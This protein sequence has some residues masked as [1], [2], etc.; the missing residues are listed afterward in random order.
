MASSEHPQTP[1]VGIQTSPDSAVSAEA[2][3]IPLSPL[4]RPPALS[5]AKFLRLRGWLDAA[6]VAA[7]LLFAFLVA[8]FPA[9]NPDFFRQLAAGRLVL[10]GNYPFG[11]D[12]F[13]Y[14]D[15]GVYIVNHS[16][17][18]GALMYLLY[19]IPSIGG[20]AVVVI[21]KALLIAALAGILL[22]VGRRPGQ[23]LWIPAACTALAILVA[24]PRF[25]LQSSCL[26]FLFLG[27][28]LW[29]LTAGRSD[30]KRL[31]WLLPPLFA[32][33][34]N[35]DSW[36]FLGPLTV[37]LYLAGGL[38]KRWLPSSE[39][40]HQPAA[41]PRAALAGAAGWFVLAAGLAAC[42]VNPHHIHALTLPPEFGLTPAGNLLDND[43]QFRR[44]FISPLQ[45]D[46]YQAYFGGS[47]AG[48][49]YWL[50]LLLSLASFGFV[51]DRAPWR[52]LLVWAALTLLSLYNVRAIPF[53]AIA[54]GPIMA[55][56]W[57]DF[58]ARLGIAGR[59]RWSLGGRALTVLAAL[60]LSI[61][62]VPGWLQTPSQTRRLGWNVR[63][64]PSLQAMAETIHGWRASSGRLPA[65]PHWFNLHQEIADYLPYFAPGE[66]VFLDHQSML[67][68]RTA[69]EDYLALRHALKQGL[70]GLLGAESEPTAARTT[71]QILRKY[72]V[73]Y[74]IFDNYSGDDAN[75]FARVLMFSSQQEW[76]LCHLSGRIA[77]FAWHDP[78]PAE[79]TEAD[80][81]Q[82][83]A[84]DLHRAA[85]G[86]QAEPAPPQPPEPPE[87]LGWWQTLWNLW[88]QPVPRPSPDAE[89]VLLYDFRY[90]GEEYPRQTN[91]LSRV[92]QRGVAAG[93]VA[94][95][96]PCG[97]MPNGLLTLSWS[98][99]Y[100]DLYPSATG[101]P[102]RE[103]GSFDQAALVARHLYV[104]GQFIE[105]PSLY[106]AVRAARRA[107]AADPENE[108]TH[109]RLGKIYQHLL[110]L[111]QE[112]RLR[113][114]PTQM[115]AIR[116]TQTLAAFQNFLRLERESG[117][118]TQALEA[119][120]VHEI[121]F[122]IFVQP[123]PNG[124]GYLD[125][126]AN[127][128]RQALD[129]RTAAGPSPGQSATKHNSEL[130]RKSNL[131]TQ[132]ESELNHRQGIYELNTR[133]SSEYDKVKAA[134][135]QGL[136]ETALTVLEQV[137]DKKVSNLTELNLLKQATA[138]ALNLGLLDKARG[139]LGDLKGRPA[140]PDQ[141][142]LYVRLAAASG[143]YAEADRL[144][145][146]ALNR[147]WQ[148]P[149]SQSAPHPATMVAISLGR[150]LLGNASRGVTKEGQRLMSMPS[151]P[152]LTNNPADLFQRTW[153]LENPSDFWLRYWRH[154]ALV[155]GLN[156]AHQNGVW[157][158]LRGWIALE[159]GR[160]VEAR[161]QFRLARDLAVLPEDWV[162]EVDKL[163]A[164]MNPQ[165]EIPGVSELGLRH[166]VLHNMS[167]GYLRW[168]EEK[169]NP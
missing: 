52:R 45:K 124:F 62:S 89:A 66:R 132:L 50:L 154:S 86:P 137:E 94:A 67:N 12:P 28:T 122:E 113:G 57:Q 99:T 32:L 101:Q 64:D 156:F 19:Q 83:L 130:D 11:A 7:V 144:L 22:R 164:W 158:L 109:L 169:P 51:L 2:S 136:I 73:R 37:A 105:P 9:S 1:P 33:W 118:S 141:L 40:A 167:V 157:H 75:S 127:H 39:T 6:V 115:S 36:F 147:A 150:A 145:A 149:Q 8:S 65:Q 120:T 111:A 35:C 21:L 131:L 142:E 100:H 29:L 81:R 148:P 151:M 77:V 138:A 59:S 95:S 134:L 14:S 146:D 34:V 25:F 43:P 4:P 140:P 85:F 139:L 53:F 123:P 47:V 24:S 20:A 42:L 60:A 88:W 119:A 135:E 97:P 63:V 3:S 69:A 82:E 41:P 106:L 44:Y 162:P 15:E 103:P 152:W 78:A 98:C 71:R 16:W 38:L 91:L 72:G 79:P 56:N 163:N 26:S 13:A 160:C 110:G 23:S 102:M 112:G 74:W 18:F 166:F 90:Q 116:L 68:S 48:Y 93:A 129:K 61:A 31:W 55:L 17:L 58:A 155:N 133:A 87:P 27:V 54:A 143:D 46:H 70:S 114:A 108:M 161:Q 117:D 128:L 107:L 125:V 80:A 96:L 10:H 84:L 30:G 168:L 159:A 165:V 5:E 104:N 76:T 92:W 49:A 126:A 121:L 153:L